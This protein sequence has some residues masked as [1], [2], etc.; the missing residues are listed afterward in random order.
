MYKRWIGMLALLG[1]FFC[2]SVQ[3]SLAGLS[4]ACFTPLCS[5]QTE[6]GADAV[7]QYYVVKSGDTLWDI[8]SKYQMSIDK[9]MEKN[10][11]N[12]KSI[13]K[14]GDRLLVSGT[15]GK[16]HTISQGET[17][18]AIAKQ[19]GIPLQAVVAANPGIKPQTLAAGQR[20]V[21]PA[22]S[23]SGLIPAASKS[24]R[25]MFPSDM[26]I[27]PLLGTITSPYG[28][29]HSGFHHGI[30][31]AAELGS[32][33]HAASGGDVCYAGYKAVY[34]RTVVIRHG[35]GLQTIY[36]HLDKIL[37]SENQAVQAGQVIGT[38]GITGRTTGPHLHFEVRQDDKTQN[39]IRYLR[40]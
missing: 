40:K 27:W 33:I 32:S 9:L 21:I 3:P 13:L 31:I 24:S 4:E 39:P 18:W 34:G 26:M 28:W 1:V 37:V 5:L 36:A 7:Q 10:G 17:L 2:A 16:V 22:R 38:V 30:D 19:Y 12:E 29:R 11:L 25:S 35:E 23:N 6:Q 20:L 15:T 8:A 14:I